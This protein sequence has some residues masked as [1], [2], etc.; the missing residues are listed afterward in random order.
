[1]SVSYVASIPFQLN[2]WMT[3]MAPIVQ[4][5][6]MRSVLKMLPR[7]IRFAKYVL[8]DILSPVSF[9]KQRDSQFPDVFDVDIVFVLG[10]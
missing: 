10:A 5:V 7:N 2:L 1:M 9:V 8:E 4:E 6:T 3:C